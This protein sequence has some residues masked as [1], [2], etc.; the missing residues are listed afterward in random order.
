[1]AANHTYRVTVIISA[2]N[3]AGIPNPFVI[4]FFS[5]DTMD[6]VINRGLTTEVAFQITINIIHIVRVYPEFPLIQRITYLM[7]FKT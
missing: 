4:A 5:F 2:K 1:M 7:L 6:I 3:F